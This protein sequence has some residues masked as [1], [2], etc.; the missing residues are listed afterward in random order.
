MN[1]I[2]YFCFK[3]KLQNR[4]DA[5]KYAEGL[6]K[7]TFVKHTLR[8]TTFSEQCYYAFNDDIN[9]ISKSLP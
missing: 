4:R 7:A 2:I 5:K 1:T 8:R 6:V 9:S 3:P